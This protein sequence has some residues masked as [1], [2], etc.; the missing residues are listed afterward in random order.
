MQHELMDLN[1]SNKSPEENFILKEEILHVVES[2]AVKCLNQEAQLKL[3]VSKQLPET[4]S[5]DV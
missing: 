5:G 4:L 1:N 2:L 3:D